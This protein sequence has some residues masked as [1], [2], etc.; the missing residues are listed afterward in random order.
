VTLLMADS[1]TPKDIPDNWTGAVA[2]YIN[3]RYAWPHAQIA[4]FDQVIRISVT[5]DPAEARRARVIDVEQFAATPADA[6]RFIRERI[7]LGHHDATVY[8]SRS[9]IPEVQAACAGLAFRFW[10]ADWTGEPHKI[11]GIDAWA[12]QYHG[13]PSLAFDTSIIY[14]EPPAKK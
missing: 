5:G 7:R 8:C 9:R 12:V 14:G 6:A 11:H 3:E 10:V 4:R 2:A 13:G 1:A